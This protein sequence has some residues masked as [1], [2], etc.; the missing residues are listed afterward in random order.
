[1][2]G[3]NHEEEH[4]FSFNELIDNIL[5]NDTDEKGDDVHHENHDPSSSNEHD[6][7]ENSGAHEQDDIEMDDVH[8]NPQSVPTHSHHDENDELPDF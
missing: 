3:E 2:S 8:D 1:M 5:T 6:N 4:D 7:I